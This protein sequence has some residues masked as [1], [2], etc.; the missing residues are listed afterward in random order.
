MAVPS[1]QNLTITR[2]DT[3]VVA[4]TMKDSAS[5]PVNIVGRTYRA[6]I[7]ASKDAST[8]AASFSC[9]ITNAS[10]GEVTCTLSAATTAN[11]AAGKYYW[12]FEETYSGVVTTILAGTVTV[13]ADVTR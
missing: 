3:E 13:L 10:A 12:D 7:R 5:T 8:I 9:A 4:I 1:T 2:G 11:L 6:Q